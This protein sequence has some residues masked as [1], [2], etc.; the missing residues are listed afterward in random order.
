MYSHLDAG[1]EEKIAAIQLGSSA[2]TRAW[3]MKDLPFNTR[4]LQ[5]TIGPE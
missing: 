3:L 4:F 2:T 5:G 1:I